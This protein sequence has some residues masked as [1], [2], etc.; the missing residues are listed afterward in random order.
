MPRRRSATPHAGCWRTAWTGAADRCT[1]CPEPVESRCPYS[2][3]KIYLRD[4]AGKDTWPNNV[5]TLDTSPEG[6]TQ[7]LRNGPYGRCV[8][9]CDNDVVDRQVRLPQG[10]VGHLRQHHE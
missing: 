7:A 3:L 2:A 6:I 9:A 1:A 8:Y 4:R 10:L 5:L